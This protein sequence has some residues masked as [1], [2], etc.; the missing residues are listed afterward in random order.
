M[1]ENCDTSNLQRFNGI[2]LRLI[3]KKITFNNRIHVVVCACFL[4]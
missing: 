2:R 4:R 3:I 1:V